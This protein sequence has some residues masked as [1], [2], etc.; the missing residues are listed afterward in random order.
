MMNLLEDIVTWQD[1]GDA[2]SWHHILNSVFSAPADD[3]A[4]LDALRLEDQGRYSD[5]VVR[6][7]RGMPRWALNPSAHH[8]MARCHEALGSREAAEVERYLARLGLRTILD[9][10]DGS[11]SRPWRVLRV[12][13]IYDVC[14]HRGVE[15]AEQELVG[16]GLDRILDT[17]GGSSWFQLIEWGEAKR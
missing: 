11:R 17:D 14:L 1:K 2:R 10:G 15:V 8:C 7:V 6:M 4:L 13:D 12:A 3:V 9:S 5:A 16:P